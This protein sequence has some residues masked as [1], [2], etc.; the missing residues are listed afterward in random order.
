MHISSAQSHGLKVII[1]E[2]V[3]GVNINSALRMDG[4]YQYTYAGHGGV[5]I[6]DLTP[7]MYTKYGIARMSLLA[8]DT[9]DYDVGGTPEQIKK[10]YPNRKIEYNNWELNVSRLGY[11]IGFEGGIDLLNAPSRLRI[12]HGAR[13]K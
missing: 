12:V 6:R 3:S 5:G 7:G 8:C 13:G 1:Q 2:N 4:L 10:L 11:F 9:A